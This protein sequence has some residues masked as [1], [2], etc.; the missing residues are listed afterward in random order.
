MAVNE[1]NLSDIEPKRHYK[2]KKNSDIVNFPINLRRE[3][4]SP[5]ANKELLEAPITTARI[6]IKVLNDVSNDQFQEE[7]NIGQLQLFE[8]EFM[9]ENNTYARFTFDVEEIDE[10]KDYNAIRK[11]LEVLENLEKGWH[12]AR[13]SKGK[14]IKSYGGVILNPNIS[15]GKISFLMSSYWIAKFLNLGVYN[16]AFFETAFALTKM[17]Q[18][19]FYLWLLEVPEK[20]TKVKFENLQETY[21]Y[22]YKDAQAFNKNVLK[23]WREKFDT[24]SNVSFNSSTKKNIIHIVPYYTKDVDL[25][26]KKK[27]VTKQKITQKLHYWKLRHKLTTDEI[28]IL[29][30]LINLDLLN[31]NLFVKSYN[32]FVSNCKKDKTKVTDYQG[33]EFIKMFQDYI[34]ET[35]KNTVWGDIKPNAYPVITDGE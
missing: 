26:L 19:L 6:F 18:V 29:K 5:K 34:I 31:Y 27:T 22:S 23:V 11:G 20:G 1:K 9:T 33:S 30:S 12:K 3:V 4:F 7:R 2:G 28:D 17:R 21:N 35:Y 25:Q 16:P 14:I 13:N 32:S 8:E 24:C 10:H 15:E